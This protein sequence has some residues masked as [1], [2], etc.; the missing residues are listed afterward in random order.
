VLLGVFY[1]VVVRWWVIQM[2]VWL[3]PRDAAKSMTRSLKES[4][5]V[6]VLLIHMRLIVGVKLSLL[7]LKVAAYRDKLSSTCSSA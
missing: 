5:I 2:P 7:N 4:L 3:F 1:M 6:V